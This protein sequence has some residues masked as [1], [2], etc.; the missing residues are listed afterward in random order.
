M[1]PKTV[2]P[3]H[4]VD[5]NVERGEKWAEDQVG[6]R[7]APDSFECIEISH[8]GESGTPFYGNVPHW[9]QADPQ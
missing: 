7:S 2:R 9:K 5:T 8:N 6:G 1:E 3:V 4:G